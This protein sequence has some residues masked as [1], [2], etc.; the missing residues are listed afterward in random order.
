[1]IHVLTLIRHN[2]HTYSRSLIYLIELILMHM[3][4]VMMSKGASGGDLQGCCCLPGASKA[5]RKGPKLSLPSSGVRTIRDVA[6]KRV[7]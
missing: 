2:F 4:V 6:V 7:R 1:M 3:V 5:D